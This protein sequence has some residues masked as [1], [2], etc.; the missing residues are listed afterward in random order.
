LD[1]DSIIIA[2][3]QLK[4]VID[5]KQDAPANEPEAIQHLK[6]SILGATNTKAAVEPEMWSTK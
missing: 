1:T 2:T 4:V 6:A 3:Q 5:G